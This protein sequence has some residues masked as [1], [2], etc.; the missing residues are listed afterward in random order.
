MKGSTGEMKLAHI[1]E[2]QSRE[3]SIREHAVG[4]ARLAGDFA[5]AFGCGEWGYGCGLLHDIGKY[6]EGFQKRLLEKGKIVDHATAGAREAFQRN[7]RVAAHCIAGHHT[8]LLDG[9]RVG[10]TGGEATL[11]GR[12]AKE[13]PDYQEFKKEIKMPNFPALSLAALGE[14]G[15][16]IAFFIR[17]LFSCLVDADFLDTEAFMSNGAVERGVYEDIGVLLQKLESYVEPWLS[18]KDA[19]TVN[20]RRTSILKACMDKGEEKQ[21]VFQMT[22]P[23]GG[24][25][26]VSSLAFALRHARKHGLS[27][28]IYVIPYTSIIEQN[29][30]IF[31]NILGKENVLEDHCNVSYDGQ[32]ELK[33]EQLAAENWDRPVVVTTNVQFFESLFSNKTSKCRKLHNIAKSVIIFDEAQMLPVQYLKPCVQAISELV[34]NYHSTAVLCTA[35]QPALRQFFPPQIELQEIC[36]NVEDQFAFFKRNE[37]RSMGELSQ[38]QLVEELGRNRQVLCILNS[39]KRV[40]AVY[41]EMKAEGTYHLSTFMY[42]KHRKKIL[43]EIRERLDQGSICRV[44]S[45]SLVEAGVDLDFQSVYRELAGV[46]SI[47]QA[48]GRCNREGKRQELCE[49]VVFNLSE[50]KECAI[51]SALRAPID[52][53]RQIVGK[54]EDI[55]SL[56]AISEYFKRLYHYRGEGTDEKNIV[57]QFEESRRNC[58][59][60]F[61]SIASQ[62]HLI[63]KEM[64]TVLIPKEPEAKDIADRLRRGEHSR[65]LFR[66]AGQFCVNIYKDDFK[67]LSGAGMLEAAASEFYILRNVEKYTEEKGL[68]PDADRGM[69]VFG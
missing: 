3:Q 23:T 42:P 55:T 19:S 49:T 32:E 45:T 8:G 39:R 61:A 43:R 48:A 35:T 56:D 21:G 34:Y 38:E 40:Q 30:Q 14:G 15:F 33:K 37:V 27:R 17:M 12:M 68:V 1:T 66:D 10:D 51:P 25:K 46:D 11:Y 58:L 47:V 5:A 67:A 26:T 20:G 22:V 53:T 4:T 65:Q 50:E 54:Y 44:I 2:D 41:E 13:L 16:T 29:A 28:I 24:G 57:E 7:N 18:N 31:K 62:F 59:F 6:S 64:V 60:P 52:V 63:E 9:G 69:G 36:P